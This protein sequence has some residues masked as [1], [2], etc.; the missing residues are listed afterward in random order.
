MIKANNLSISW[1]ENILNPLL[2]LHARP[3]ESK[4]FSTTHVFP[5]KNDPCMTQSAGN[6]S[7]AFYSLQRGP[8][9][10]PINALMLISVITLFFIGVG[11]M[12][13]LA[14][15]ATMPFLIT[16]GMIEYSYFVL[17]MQFDINQQRLQKYRAN[18]L[19]SPTFDARKKGP[20]GTNGLNGKVI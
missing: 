16:Y 17:C 10:V 12:N 20:N 11:E 2:L 13:R 8:N 5:E 15:L 1:F 7:P 9:K 6:N 3:I 14:T 18:G 4:A 19:P